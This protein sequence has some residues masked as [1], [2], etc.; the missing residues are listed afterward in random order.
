MTERKN[1]AARIAANN[2][3]AAGAYDRISCVVPK[4]QREEIKSVAAAAGQSANAYIIA[5]IRARLDGQAEDTPQDQQTTR[6]GVLP[7]E[8]ISTTIPPDAQK[9]AHA[10]AERQGRAVDVWIANAIDA[11]AER[12]RKMGALAQAAAQAREDERKMRERQN[13]KS[14]DQ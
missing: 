9:T 2:R 11:Q 7:D 3:W 13:N 12:E 6:D 14:L 10:A 5:A 4:G 8:G 1:S